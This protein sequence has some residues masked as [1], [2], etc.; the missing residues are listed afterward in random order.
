LSR[1][2]PRVPKTQPN[3]SLHDFG[4]TVKTSLMADLVRQV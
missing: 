1:V 3:P 4:R 2:N